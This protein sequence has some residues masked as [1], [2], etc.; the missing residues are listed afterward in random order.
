MKKEVNKFIGKINNDDCIK[1]MKKLPDNC[2]DLTVTS[3]PYDDLRDYENNLVWDY[4]TFRKVA[5]E[6]YRI[7]KKRRSCC[8]GYWR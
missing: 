7:T 6:L 5:R 2:I 1:F 4:N 8:L 3:P